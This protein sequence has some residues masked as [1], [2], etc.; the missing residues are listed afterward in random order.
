MIHV[1]V[2][3]KEIDRTSPPQKVMPRMILNYKL[4]VICEPCKKSLENHLLD[5]WASWVKV[6]DDSLS[7]IS[8][9]DLMRRGSAVDP[10]RR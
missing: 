7:T 4:E 9:V 8:V 3:C 1:C 5:H 2:G 10:D 6:Q